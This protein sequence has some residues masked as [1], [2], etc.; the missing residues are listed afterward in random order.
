MKLWEKDR[1]CGRVV[2]PVNEWGTSVRWKTFRAWA[3]RNRHKMLLNKKEVYE[4]GL[5]HQRQSM[6]DFEE[7]MELLFG[8]VA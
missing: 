7:D 3:L 8:D 6:E 5:E 1:H 4:M 2:T